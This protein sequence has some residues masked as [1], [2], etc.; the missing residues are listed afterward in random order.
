LRSRG[1][2]TGGAIEEADIEIVFERFDLKRLCG[3]GQEEVLRRLA[4]IKVLRN[5]AKHLETEAPP[6]DNY[7]RERL[8]KR[9]HIV[10]PEPQAHR[11][12]VRARRRLGVMWC[13]GALFAAQFPRG[14]WFVANFVLAIWETGL[15]GHR[16]FVFSSL[17]PP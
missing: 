2:A 17:L 4:K 11:E 6:R 9:A 3:L 12:F 16:L 5:G 14:R 15:A 7:P 1:D 10:R 13:C 8:D